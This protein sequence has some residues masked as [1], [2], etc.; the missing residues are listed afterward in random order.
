MVS[1][2]ANPL[3]SALERLAVATWDRLRDIKAFSQRPE[4]FNSVRLGE[5]TIT[6]LAMLDLC[7]QGLTR[8]IFLQTP[9]HVERFRGTD[10]EWWLGS[11]RTGWFRLA[12]QA[13]KLDMKQD[14]YVSL[15]YK[16]KGVLQVKTL[17][18]Y[19]SRNRATALYCLYNYSGGVDGPR[20]W[21]CCQRS[22][23]AEELGCSLARPSRVRQA[24]R[25]VGKR[26]F[27]F[28]HQCSSTL[29]W[30]CMASCPKVR[31][32]FSDARRLYGLQ[33]AGHADVGDI[34]FPLI[35]LWSYY[36]ELP[37]YRPR[38][39]FGR[40]FL[41]HFGDGLDDEMARYNIEVVD[42][43]DSLAEFYNLEV[44]VPRAINVTD[45]GI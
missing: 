2:P 16:P 19:A 26:T 45:L 37:P 15:A 31:G 32:A 4:P 23:R 17:E 12:V 41:P 42:F 22:F 24:I 30:Q 29:P 3:E 13:K 14:R 34:P 1:S 8:S 33:Q 43:D 25:R 5:T 6:D 35:D 7:R 44:G 20:H 39:R 21:H 40:V 38:S 27:D 18:N 10:F 36:P 28:L 11:R 9:Q